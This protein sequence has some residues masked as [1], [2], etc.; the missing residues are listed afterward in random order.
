MAATVSYNAT[1]FTAT[2]TPSALLANSTTYTATISGVE[3]LLG[4]LL[5][6][7]FSWSFTTGPAPTVTTEV[8]GSGA[9][10]VAVASTIS[11]TFNEGVQSTTI[12]VTLKSSAGTAVAGSLAYNN[13]TNTETFT[14]T[15]AL[16]YAT[17]YTVTVSGAKDTAGDAMSGPVSWSFTTAAS[18]PSSGLVAEWQFN[19]GSGTTTAD[20]TG[21]GNTG[22]LLGS[23]AWTTGLVGPYALSFSSSNDGHVVV[24]D[25]ASLEFTAAQSYSL[26]AWVDVTSLPGQWTGI[27]G[28]SRD[29]GNYYE[30]YINPS[31]EWVGSSGA[32][33]ATDL[34]GPTVSTGWSL[35]SMV[36]NGSAGTRSLYVDGVQ[37]ASGAA[38][39]SNGTGA[40]CIGGDNGI[41]QYFN[42]TIDDVRVYN[43]AL[44]SSQ[45]Q[46]LFTA[47]PPTVIA[48][49]PDAGAGVCRSHRPSVQPS[50][51]RY[52]RA[53]FNSF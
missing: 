32:G 23:V 47:A 3:S 20:N 52:N 48:E 21:D 35:V 30:I 1:T 27:V 44:S 41:S 29:V 5:G 7:P 25:S 6:S 15:A 33:G 45:V 18:A 51:S 36:Q 4:E 9:T 46:G 38:E 10:G 16:A 17:T 12:A 2:L 37:V 11:A 34:V 26:T 39:A 42:G 19:E 14:P 8:P 31:N 50:A 22:G 43:T 49:S 24:P 28:K 40:F 13:T 53:R